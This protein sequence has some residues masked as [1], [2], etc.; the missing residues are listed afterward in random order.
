MDLWTIIGFGLLFWIA[1]KV[2]L[3]VERKMKMRL[4][5]LQAQADAQP[6]SE[7]GP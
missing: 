1:Y 5:A 4:K 2:G 3:Y 7:R 6:D